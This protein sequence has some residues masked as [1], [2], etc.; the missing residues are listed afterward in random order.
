MRLQMKDLL[1]HLKYKFRNI[2]MHALTESNEHT[3]K[4]KHDGIG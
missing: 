3:I 1:T 4:Y 2:T